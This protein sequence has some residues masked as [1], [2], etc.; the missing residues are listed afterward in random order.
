VTSSR[1]TRALSIGRSRAAELRAVLAAHGI[2]KTFGDLVA[3]DNADLELRAGVHALLGENGAGKSTLV[4]VIYGYHRADEGEVLIDGRPVGISSPA[5]ARRLGIGLVFQEF[6]LIPALTVTENVALFLPDLKPVLDHD[7][8]A[9]QIRATSQRYG[10]AVD[11]SSR[12]GALSLPE[13]QRVEIVRVLLAGARILILDEP[14]SALPPQEIKA[15]FA[16]LRRLRD[17]GYPIVLITHKLPE[18]FE[19][20]DRVTV[21]RHGVVVSSVSTDD[22]TE[23]A[24][25]TMMFGGLQDA[26]RPAQTRAPQVDIPALALERVT[27]VGQGRPLFDLE[28]MIAP[29]EIV[30]VA[31]VAGNGQRELADTVVGVSRIKHGRRL[32]F[33]EDTTKWSVRKIRE[34]GVGFIPESALDE[35][36]IGGMTLAENIALGSPRRFSRLGGFSLDRRAVKE[37]WAGPFA[38]LGLHLPDPK[39]RAKTLSG[40]TAQRFVLARELARHPKFLIALYPTRG[41]DVRTA[42]TVHHLLLGARAGGCGILLIS[43]DLNELRELTDR[44]LVMRNGRIVAEVDSRASDVYQIGRLMTGEDNS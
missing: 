31:G 19:V 27:S 3:V 8:I 13:Q 33:G 42:T 22:V 4:K 16:V 44:L 9:R 36:L 10:L 14:T 43:Q 32:L 35:E 6:T 17:D 20:A 40:G 38:E 2:V 28:L 5:D 23:D 41:L 21:M 25:V 18:V 29:G 30:G 24:L 12:V 37:E 26:A 11:P 15:L 1:G 39:T 7:E 34:A